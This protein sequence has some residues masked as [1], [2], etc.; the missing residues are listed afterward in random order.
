M[1]RGRPAQMTFPSLFYHVHLR[2]RI[3]GVGEAEIWE[4]GACP[5]HASGM[6]W[7]RVGAEVAQ[8]SGSLWKAGAVPSQQSCQGRGEIQNLITW[9]ASVLRRGRCRVLWNQILKQCQEAGENPS[10]L[11]SQK[12][13]CFILSLGFELLQ[14]FRWR[15][16]WGVD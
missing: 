6:D 9:E 10:S 8:S 2:K 7:G 11:L 1:S 5:G 4:Q 13:H 3:W 12:I 15:K 16:S 14:G